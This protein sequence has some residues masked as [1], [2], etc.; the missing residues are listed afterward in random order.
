MGTV[1]AKIK[2]MP[3]TSE[4][5]I[6]EL[7]KNIESAIPKGTELKGIERQ[8][9]AFGLV[10]LYPTVLI[11]DGEGGTDGVEEAL[12]KVEGV[13]SVAVEAVGLI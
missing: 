1:A 5:D 8:P 13:G 11:P 9:I 7:E 10:A 12:S 6:E 2:V 3:E 4:I